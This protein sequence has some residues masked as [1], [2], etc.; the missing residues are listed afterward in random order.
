[1]STNEPDYIH[2]KP[3][4]RVY[5]QW[6]GEG[7]QPGEAAHPE[8]RTYA[9]DR[10]YP[11]DICYVRWGRKAQ[12]E[13]N[14]TAELDGARARIHKLEAEVARLRAEL[15]AAIRNAND[16]TPV[17]MPPEG[18]MTVQVIVS[19]DYY[20]EFDGTWI[21]GTDVTTCIADELIV[22]WRPIPALSQEAS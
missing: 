16:W 11:T 5:L 19:A 15:E 18:T 2:D 6:Y 10:I 13:I 3:P 17:S 12:E 21:V 22:A 9:R 8:E 20:P 7:G 4:Q 1:M 14:K